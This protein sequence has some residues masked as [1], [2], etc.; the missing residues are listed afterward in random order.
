M[1]V[2]EGYHSVTPYLTVDGAAKL[3]EFMERAFGA[4]ERGRM[5]GPKGTIGHAEVTI[6]DSAVMV[7]DAG[8]QWP[9]R[10]GNLHLYVSDCDDTYQRA[11]AAGATSVREPTTEFYGDR[12]AGVD[13]PFGNR[14]W[15]ATRVEDVPPDEMARRAAEAAQRTA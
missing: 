10:T 11:L 6:G 9:V 7:G 1:S 5:P 4:E 8:D 15:I 14:W 12:M 13:D 2:P 3:I